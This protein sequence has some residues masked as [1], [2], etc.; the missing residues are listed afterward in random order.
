[1]PNLKS[2]KANLVFDGFAQIDLRSSKLVFSLKNKKKDHLSGLG[3][4]TSTI[5]DHIKPFF[6]FILERKTFSEM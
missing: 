4:V 2:V 1:M 6:Y 3:K 5:K